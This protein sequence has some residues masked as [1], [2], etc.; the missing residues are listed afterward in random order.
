L[1]KLCHPLQIA[2]IFVKI[3]NDICALLSQHLPK[4]TH[5]IDFGEETAVATRKKVATMMCRFQ[6][7][8]ILI[9]VIS[10]NGEHKLVVKFLFQDVTMC[11]F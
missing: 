2:S 8:A 6:L 9:Y 10:E 3:Y 4:Q 7:P 5:V 1:F 11:R